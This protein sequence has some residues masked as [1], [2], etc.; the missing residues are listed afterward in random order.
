MV[1]DI[2]QVVLH[3]TTY[4]DI[5]IKNQQIDKKVCHDQNIFATTMAP[6]NPASVVLTLYDSVIMTR[7]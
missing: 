4:P 7:L 2:D 3:V 6:T 1:N 5:Y